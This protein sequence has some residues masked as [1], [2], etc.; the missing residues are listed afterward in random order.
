MI[1]SSTRLPSL[2]GTKHFANCT[3]YLSSNLHLHADTMT[4][5]G[6]ISHNHKAHFSYPKTV[7]TKIMYTTEVFPRNKTVTCTKNKNMSN[8]VPDKYPKIASPTPLTPSPKTNINS[9]CM[10]TPQYL[11]NGLNSHMV[12][13]ILLECTVLRVHITNKNDNHTMYGELLFGN[14]MV[15]IQT[16]FTNFYV[17]RF[18]H[19]LWYMTGFQ[20]FWVY[21][22]GCHMWGQEMLTLSRTPDFTCF[23]EFIISPIHYICIIYYCICQLQDLSGDNR[24]IY[25]HH[26]RPPD[27]RRSSPTESWLSNSVR[28]ARLVANC[29]YQ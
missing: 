3:I 21:R 11:L 5:Y 19:Q 6:R 4:M 15:V 26:R 13:T 20:L 22:D 28:S 17:E 18:L 8:H 12:Y 1:V 14:S 7:P 16:L 27:R 2:L 23:G 9:F 25:V 29:L 10:F 24:S